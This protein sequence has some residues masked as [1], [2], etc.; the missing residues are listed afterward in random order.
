MNQEDN[1]I[2]AEQ[3][4]QESLKAI[5]TIITNGISSK[6]QNGEFKFSLNLEGVHETDQKD[7][8]NTYERYGYYARISPNE[9]LTIKWEK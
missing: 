6:T 5:R 8:V 9:T 2:K 7:L 4:Y 1:L 3:R